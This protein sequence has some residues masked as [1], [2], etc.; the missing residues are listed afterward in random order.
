MKFLIAP[1]DNA[2]M[3]RGCPLKYACIPKVYF[4]LPP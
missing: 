4:I 1:L 2:A 3:V